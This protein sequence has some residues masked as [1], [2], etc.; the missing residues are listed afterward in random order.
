V[1]DR[2][3]VGISE[4]CRIDFHA[5]QQWCRW[6]LAQEFSEAAVRLVPDWLIH[7]IGQPLL[8]DWGWE[9]SWLQPAQAHWDVLR[10]EV[11]EGL[12]RSLVAIDRSNLALVCAHGLIQ[13]DP[14]RET[15][16][17]VMIE[18][19]LRSGQRAEARFQFERLSEML[20]AELGV[21]P[22]QTAHRL[23]KHLYP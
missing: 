19:L 3:R 16:W 9:D 15:A 22:S 17:E 1:G 12:S 8:T 4:T 18:A 6:L 5:A 23:I 7:L 13:Q 10:R 2:Q 21:D 20:S 11:M 14:L